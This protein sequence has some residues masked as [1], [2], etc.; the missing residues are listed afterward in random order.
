MRN[1]GIEILFDYPYSG[2]YGLISKTF[3]TKPIR[4]FLDVGFEMITYG[5]LGLL[6]GAMIKYIIHSQK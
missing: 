3:L 4:L 1:Q 5:I 2:R 6:N